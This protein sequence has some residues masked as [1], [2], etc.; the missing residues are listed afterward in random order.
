M[1]LRFGGDFVR[2]F[3]RP[4]TRYRAAGPMPRAQLRVMPRRARVE[5]LVA[6]ARG[7]TYPNLSDHRCNV[8][9][10]VARVTAALHQESFA[11]DQPYTEGDWVVLPFQFRGEST[12]EGAR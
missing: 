11:S 12:K 6:P 2:E 8:E 10:D 1:M 3:G 5:I 4:W 7:R 9:Y